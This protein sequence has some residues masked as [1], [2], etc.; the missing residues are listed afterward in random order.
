MTEKKTTVRDLKTF[1]EAVEFASDTDSW[2]PSARQWAKIR[3]MIESLEEV[4]APQAAHQTV[5]APSQQYIPP[6]YQ[7]QIPVM[8]AMP[9]G[10]SGL[11]AA[12]PA[13]SMAPT[14]GMPLSMGQGGAVRA[15][16]ID[17]SNGQY[18]SLYA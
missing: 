11:T 4:A 2:V 7:P 5:A 13:P 1:I 14:G 10:P 16:D 8:P 9:V 6:T 17:T 18:N 12:R 15:P 3:S